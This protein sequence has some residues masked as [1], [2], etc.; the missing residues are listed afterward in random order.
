MAGEE[1][2]DPASTLGVLEE[3]LVD[4]TGSPRPLGLREVIMLCDVDDFRHWGV[5]VWHCGALVR[6]DA[7][8]VA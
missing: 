2:N 5:A 4:S 3:R 6:H 7:R 1:L 8:H